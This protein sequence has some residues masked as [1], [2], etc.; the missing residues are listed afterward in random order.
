M[1][2]V[3]RRWLLLASPVFIGFLLF[4]IVPFG[5]SVY[6]SVIESAFSEEFVGWKNYADALSNPY[7]R[8]AVRNALEII[9]AFVP[10]LVGVALLLAVL[11]RRAGERHRLLRAFLLMPMLLPSAAVANV[12]GML[13]L[14]SARWPVFLLFLW[15]NSGFLMVLLMAGTSVIPKELY[16]AASVDGAS[17]V[18]QFFAITISQLLSTLFFC[19]VLAVVYALRIFKEAF[20]LYGAYPTDEIYLVQHY[21]NN[22]FAK[23]NYPGL[24]AGSM[25]FSAIL[26]AAILLAL[27]L[28]RRMGGDVG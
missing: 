23:L 26:F 13:R 7:F 9:V 20:L 27:R 3:R 15:K 1:R 22:Y 14:G 6:Y 2:A 17:R 28:E 8:L 4:Y 19:V 10:A 5:F 18:R 16:E 24:T 25:L 11:V 21:L 12:F